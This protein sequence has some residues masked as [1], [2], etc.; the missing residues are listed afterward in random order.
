M[1]TMLRHFVCL[2]LAIAGTTRAGGQEITGARKINATTVEVLLDN[3]RHVTLDFHGERIVRLFRDDAG[4]IARDPEAKPEARILHGEAREKVGKVEVSRDG[5]VVAVSTRHVSVR[6]EKGKMS[7]VDLT[8]GTVVIEE[9]A[10]PAIEKERVTLT[11]TENRD[12]YFYGGGVQNGRFSHKGSAIAI[13]NQNSWTDGG[14]ASPTPFFWS[15]RG[16]AIMWHTFAKGRYDFG[17]AEPGVVKLYHETGYMD[18]FII[19][20]EKPAGILDGLYLLTGKPV[21]LPKF[22]FYQG[23]LNAYNRDYWREDSTGTRFEDGKRYKESQKANDG[24]RESLNGEEGNYQF[25]ARA[26]IDR[27]Q[28]N[29]M[30]LG[31]LLPNDGYGAGYG[32]EETLDGNI[33]NLARLG[34]YARARG[35]EIGLWT[36]SDLHPKEGVSALLQR[37]IVKEVR[38]AGVRVLKTDVAWVGAGYSFG[39]NGVNDAARIMNYYGND[40]RPFIITLDGWAGTQ[41][42]AGVWTGD[43]TGGTWEYIRFHVPTYIGAGLSGQPNIMSDMDGIFGGKNPAVNPRDFQWKTFTPEQLNMDGWGTNEKYPHAMGEPTTSINRWYLK[44]KAELM[45]YTYSIAREAVDGLPMVRALFLEYPDAYTMGTAT[46]YE[47]L[48]GPS[49]LVAPV[50]QATRPDEHGNDIRDGIYLPEGTWIDYFSGERHEGKRVLNNFDAPVWKLPLFVKEGAIV[51]VT[52]PHDNPSGIDRGTRVYELYPHGHTTFV[53]YDDDGVSGQYKEGKGT[54]TLVESMADERGHVTVTVHPTRGDFDG[55]TREKRTE[56]RVNVTAKPRKVTA[57]VGGRRVKLNE[58]SSAEEF[59]ERDDVYFYDHAPNLNRF[60]TRGSDFEKMIITKNPRLLVKLAATDITARDVTLALDGFRFEPVDKLRVT[61]G[62]LAAPRAGETV[63]T[64][65]ALTPTWERVT[66]AD[67]YE[68]DFD[69]TRFSTIKDTALLFDGLTPETAYSFKLRA[70]NRDGHSPWTS[71]EATTLTNPL[72]FAI[73][74]I[75]GEVSLPAQRGQG[76]ANLFDFDENNLWH[77]RWDTTATS[78]DLVADLRTIN[79]LEKLHYLPRAGWSNGTILAGTISHSLDK[80]NWTEAGSFDWQQ[81]ETVNPFTFDEQPTARYVKL[82]VTRSRGGFGSGRELYIFK[83]PGTESLLPGDINRDRRVDENDLV[84]YR[85]YTGLRRGDADFDGYVSHGDINRNGLIDAHDISVA[86][87]PPGTRGNLAGKIEI[88]AAKSRYRAGEIVEVRVRGIDLRDVNAFSFALPY[89]ERDYT[90]VGV[91]PLALRAM[92]DFTND[93]LHANGQKA[94]YPTFVNVGE[95]ET[96]QGTLDLCILKFKAARDVTF[97][98]E[99]IDGLLV[100]KSPR[101]IPF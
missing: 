48:Y 32:Q 22:G 34:D 1:N 70:V 91:Q 33:R 90:F 68:I 73:R 29:E 89:D 54:T 74:D 53:E 2:T 38:D 76:I 43:Q 58:V 98:L 97:N 25:S 40:S 86:A 16:Y 8:R 45:P 17:A 66:N 56:F 36:Q 13:E 35:V 18:L 15:T 10:P 65:H 95:Q 27:Y 41:R 93:R 50:Y 63:A 88:R 79:R 51:P 3:D 96:L 92:E 37:D 21:L 69:G 4:G 62:P 42:Y 46:R 57:R 44:F 11:L 7:V 61:G 55:F 14:V 49:F 94:L 81:R 78:L 100:D 9:I 75:V 31:W 12:E 99:A 19:V 47:F 77:T 82:H 52:Y 64:P 84:S 87:A 39:L 71:L 72:A 6:F 24:I 59:R 80:E 85:N 26:V 5:D 30:P 23:H 28:A 20:D 60:A 67:Y 101:S 83:V